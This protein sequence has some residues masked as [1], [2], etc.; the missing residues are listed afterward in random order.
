[1]MYTHDQCYVH[2][3]GAGWPTQRST[4]A[5]YW[6]EEDFQKASMSPCYLPLPEAFPE[7]SLKEDTVYSPGETLRRSANF[8]V[9]CAWNPL[10][11]SLA[12][13]DSH[14]VALKSTMMVTEQMPPGL[15]IADMEQP[16]HSDGEAAPIS[17]RSTVDTETAVASITRGKDELLGTPEMPT[18]GSAQHSLRNCKPCAFVHKE[19]CQSGVE[20]QFCHLCQPG[21]KKM[22]KKER[23]Q[24]RR[25][26]N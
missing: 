14:P 15:S 3:L 11:T 10:K 23:K 12:I 24:Q 9:S 17:S 1:M 19:G 7:I 25:S 22:R 16:Q 13:P 6:Q 4:T 5:S 8:S 21:E 18:R 2:G 26:S 20:C